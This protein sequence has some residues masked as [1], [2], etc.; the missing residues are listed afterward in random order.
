MKAIREAIA[1]VA[2][3]MLALLM[4]GLSFLASIFFRR[5]YTA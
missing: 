3:L 2:I 5:A 4:F 1:N